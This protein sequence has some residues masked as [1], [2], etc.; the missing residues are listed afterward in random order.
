MSVTA[1]YGTFNP[2]LFSGVR[3]GMLTLSKEVPSPDKCSQNAGVWWLC[4][5]DCGGEV[6][7]PTRR[8]NY[9]ARN[10]SNV[11]CGCY[12]HL[13]PKRINARYVRTYVQ[14]QS[15]ARQRNYFFDLSLEEFVKIVSSPCHYCGVEHSMETK[16]KKWENVT[17]NGMDRVDNTQGYVASNVVPCCKLCNRAK[18][19]LP[20]EDFIEWLDRIAEFRKVPVE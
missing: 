9:A 14:S 2:V 17:H 12:G 18:N 4:K 6:L 13:A 8:L 7:K 1:K 19:S 11:N 3:V 5:C 15:G 10:H 20:V 16:F